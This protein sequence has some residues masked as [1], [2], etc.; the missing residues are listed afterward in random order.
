MP[1]AAQAADPF[2]LRYL[3][4]AQPRL[5]A[6]VVHASDDFFAPK[7]RLIEPADPVFVPGKYDEN[8][9]WMD[10]WESRRRRVPGHDFCV[11]RLGL[12][13]SV[14][15]VDI[16]TAHFNGN[17][18]VAAWLEA[19]DEEGPWEEASGWRELVPRTALGPDRHQRVAVT[20]KAPCTW[21]RLHIDPDG[22]VARLRVYGVAVP[23]PGR[24]SGELVDLVAATSGGEVI[25]C[26]DRHFGSPHH[27][28]MPGRGADMGDGWETRRRRGPGFDSVILRLGWVGEIERV[29]VD[30]AH[31]KGNYPDRCSLQARPAGEGAAPTPDD[32]ELITES[33]G[34]PEVLPSVKLGADQEHT[35]ER[36][37][38]RSGAV[39]HVRLNIFPD[40]GVSRLR[41]FGR[42]VARS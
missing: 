13:A 40:G 38:R 19:C 12:R 4:L 36:E 32:A 28:L 31:F 2:W 37:L 33:E 9:K 14:R 15:G 20:D 41:I 23:A 42:P 8:G 25:A 29:L 30:T 6:R 35:F 26:N 18:P 21:L 3:N 10:G 39:T 34:W 5:G 24:A 7:E 27:L 22:G 16:D 11:V 1:E 17:Q